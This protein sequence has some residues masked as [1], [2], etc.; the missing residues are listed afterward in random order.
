MRV[1][2]KEYDDLKDTLLTLRLD[3]LGNS[4]KSKLG[5]IN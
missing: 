5:E 4:T 1:V 3:Y 2:A